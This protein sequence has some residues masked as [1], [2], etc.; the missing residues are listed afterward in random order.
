MY[1]YTTCYPLASSKTYVE[2]KKDCVSVLSKVI[3][4][5]NEWRRN[6]GIRLLREGDIESGQRMLF[7][8]PCK[9][10]CVMD[11]LG[12]ARGISLKR[13]DEIW[14]RIPESSRNLLSNMVPGL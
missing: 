4:A 5:T 8:D 2:N 7:I 1:Q 13:L 12:P 6:K 10:E 11:L 14:G 3:V 9:N